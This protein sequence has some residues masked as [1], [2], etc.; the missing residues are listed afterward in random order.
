MATADLCLLSV[1][2][3]PDD[4]ASKGAPTVARYAAEGVRAVLVCCTGGEEGD[5]Q[6]PTLREPGQPFHGLT[7]EQE[8]ALLTQMRPGELARSAEIIG[9]QRTVMLGY[10]DSGMAESE[11]NQHP[12]SFHRASLDEAAGRLVEVIRAERPQVVLTYGDDHSGYPHP[13]HIRVH[14]VSL[15]AFD[16][17]GDPA[18]YPEAGDPFQPLKLY[19]TVWARARILAV[20]EALLARRGSSPYDDRWLQRPDQD[21]RITT[22]LDVGAFLTARSGALRAHATQV[23][24]NEAHWFGLSDAELAEVYP[25]EDWILARSLVGGPAPGAYED[26]LFAGVRERVA[27]G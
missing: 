10:R 1:H 8:R 17:A 5:I 7:P 12:D 4:E 27:H 2:A 20:H 22:R 13:D 9:Y 24:P 6:N 14:E 11:A 18:W 21:A 15:L 25:Y 19:Y 16:R 3:H 23:D 26:D